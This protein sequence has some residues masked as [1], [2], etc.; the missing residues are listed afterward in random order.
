MDEY[1]DL[2]SPNIDDKQVEK[3]SSN[4]I[5]NPHNYKVQDYKIT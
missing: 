5:K 2:V 3:L 1:F 4:I